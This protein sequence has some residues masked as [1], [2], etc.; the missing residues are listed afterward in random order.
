MNCELCGDHTDNFCGCS[1]C[2]KMV[3][4]SCLAAV[5]LDEESSQDNNDPIC[6][7]CF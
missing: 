5:D 6:E 2:A 3:C 7:E 4:P 1:L